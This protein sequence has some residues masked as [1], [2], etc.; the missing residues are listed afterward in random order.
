MEADK[1]LWPLYPLAIQDDVPF[2]LING[3]LLAGY[4]QHPFSHLDWAEKHGK[5]RAQPLR[6]ADDP[7]AAVDKLIAQ[8]QIGRLC[9]S[10]TLKIMLRYEAWQAIAHLV[11]VPMG[12]NDF[13]GAA[14]EERKKLAAKLKIRWDV[15]KQNYVAK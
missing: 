14:W 4:P 10:D 6:P 8:P 11:R 12:G 2:L 7:I 13:N 3:V 5:L 9:G 1:S 15:D